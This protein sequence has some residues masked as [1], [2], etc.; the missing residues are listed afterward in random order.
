MEDT[1]LNKN[2]QDWEFL[3][4]RHQLNKL[5]TK[6]DFL[7]N[8][9]IKLEQQIEKLI[10][11]NNKH[12]EDS[13]KRKEECF[14][15]ILDKVDKINEK[16][17]SNHKEYNK[18]KDIYIEILTKLA[19]KNK[20]IEPIL[21]KL[22]K[23]DKCYDMCSPSIMDCLFP[24]RVYNRLWRAGYK[25]PSITLDDINLSTDIVKIVKETKEI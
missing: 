23:K 14:E 6:I 12:F 10:N 9:V 20:D 8:K 17:T 13:Y 5:N 1:K 4:N 18:N 11:I 3:E 25:G 16:L 2:S 24:S 19:E 22:E 21:E 15:K 7:E